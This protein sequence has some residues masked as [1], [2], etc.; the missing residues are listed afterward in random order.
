MCGRCVCGKHVYVADRYMWQIYLC[1]RYICGKYVYIYISYMWHI[2]IYVAN[3]CIYMWQIH[4]WQIYIYIYIYMGGLYVANMFMWQIHM[5]QIY[6]WQVY[7]WQTSEVGGL[8]PTGES[9]RFARAFTAVC[10]VRM[11]LKIDRPCLFPFRPEISSLFPCEIRCSLSLAIDEIKGI[12]V[13]SSE[14]K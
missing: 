4:M 1:G 5:W 2:C 6:M 3:I 14:S 11:D 13:R 7:M 10:K 9:F 8:R 12:Q